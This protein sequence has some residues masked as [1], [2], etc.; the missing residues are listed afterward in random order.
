MKSYKELRVWQKA[1][2]LV[3]EVYKLGKSLPVEERFGLKSQMERAAVSI[4]VNIAEGWGRGSTKEYI[5]FLRI[6]RGSLMELETLVLIANN[7]QLWEEENL[8]VVVNSIQK[9]GMMLNS[10]ISSLRSK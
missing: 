2:E 8:E 10:L 3:V 9:I 4:P 5:Q 6:A 1:M 7:L